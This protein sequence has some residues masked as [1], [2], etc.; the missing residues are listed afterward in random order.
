MVL[1]HARR[2][3][4]ACIRNA[5]VGLLWLPSLW[6]GALCAAKFSLAT[7]AAVGDW[8]SVISDNVSD[9]GLP[10]GVAQNCI[11]LYRRFLICWASDYPRT[12]DNPKPVDHTDDWQNAIL[13][14]SRLKICATP[15]DIQK[16][17]SKP[18]IFSPPI[19]FHSARFT[20]HVSPTTFHSSRFTSPTRQSPN[21]GP[22][23]IVRQYGFRFPR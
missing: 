14:Y 21:P 3:I 22:L 12:F 17:R 13:R 6:V 2:A 11:L 18:P 23:A 16:P 20:Y 10:E 15:S 4:P 5:V 7:A 9:R 19:M 8:G 1:P